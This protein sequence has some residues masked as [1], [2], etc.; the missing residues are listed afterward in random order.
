MAYKRQGFDFRVTSLLAAGILLTR[1]GIAINHGSSY[2]ARK[3]SRQDLRG[4]V[5]PSGRQLPGVTFYNVAADISHRWFSCSTVLETQGCGTRLKIHPQGPRLIRAT[6]R[7]PVSCEP[8]FNRS[9]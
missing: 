3:K 1:R 8:S 2:R 7:E 6:D 5:L 4:I 9:S